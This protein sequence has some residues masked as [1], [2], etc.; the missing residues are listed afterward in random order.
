[1][2]RGLLIVGLGNPWRGDD[3]AGPAVARALGDDPRV[4]VNEGEPIGLIDVWSGADEVILVDTVSSG[5]PAGTVHRFD[6]LTTLPLVLGRGSTHA[7]GLAETLELARILDRLS[8][9]VSV[10]GIEGERFSAG[11]ELSAP[12]RAAVETVR[13]ELEERLRRDAPGLDAA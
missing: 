2:T 3:G 11:E 5:A 6:L 13:V 9:K 1:V 8:P 4:L 7:F 10:Y 12:V